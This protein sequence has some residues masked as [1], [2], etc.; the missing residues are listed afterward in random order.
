VEVEVT[1]STGKVTAYASTVDN[2]T[3][4]P[5]MVWP[6]IKGA[7][8][9]NRYTLPGMAT[10]NTGLAV[11]RSDVRIFNAGPSTP[12]TLTFY[13]QGNPGAPVVRELT[14]GSGEVQAIDDI[15]GGLFA[16]GNGAGGSLVI[17]TPANAPIVATA[18]TYNQT[19]NGTYGQ[20]IPGVT[21][22]QS[23]GAG[24]RALN[25][26]QLEQSSRIRT[27]VGFAETS[28]QPATLEVSVILPDTKVTPFLTVDL[29]ANEFKQIPLGAFNLGD[30]VYNARVTVKVIG[31]SG[32]V[33]AYGS[34]IDMTTQDPTYVPAQ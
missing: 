7:T 6:V 25:I 34:A 23:I 17:T 11:W 21:V 1:S 13:P 10:I 3:N 24:D 18:R 33:T 4:D 27:N 30:A 5:L 9:T 31:G 28:G 8:S 29:A 16:Q 15:L 22:A 14:V 2:S 32:K 20:F 12:A 19:A 26:L